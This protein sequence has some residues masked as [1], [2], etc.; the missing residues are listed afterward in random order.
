MCTA[1]RRR[2]DRCIVNDPTRRGRVRLPRSIAVLRHRDYALVQAGAAISNLGTWM[3]YVGIGWALRGLTSWEFALGLSFVAQF[4]PSLVLAP[5]AGVLADHFDRRRIVIA[6][7]IAQAIPP[8]AIG[9][10]ITQQRLTIAWLLGLAT[11]GGTAQAVSMPAGSAIIPRLVP[12]DETHQ[13]VTFGTAAVNITR[14]GGPAIGG[15]AIH[16]WGLDW[17]FYLNAMSFGAVVIAWAIVRPANTRSTV[18]ER[19][20]RG[21]LREGIAY[22]RANHLVRRLLELNMVIGVFMFHAPLMPAFARDVL[23]GDSWT[24]SLLTSATGVGAVLGAFLAGELRAHRHRWRAVVGAALLCPAALILFAASTR[25]ALSVVALVGFGAGYFLFL[26]TSQSMLILASPDEYRGRVMGLFGMSSVG[27]V[28]FA[29]LAGGALA[30]VIG[31]RPAVAVAAV[32]VLAYASWVAVG[33]RRAASGL[34]DS[35]HALVH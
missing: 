27:A 10:F 12:P 20:A 34:S 7:T 14:V 18:A 9:W 13:A 17:A 22:A 6:G 26:A 21:T 11:L 31:P 4:G 32:I 19:A 29:G 33:E 30:G 3:Q 1:S 25:V 16:L 2:V 24:Y 35:E 8:I 28:P 5:G 23:R 15:A